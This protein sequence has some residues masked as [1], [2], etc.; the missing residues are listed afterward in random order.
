MSARWYRR[1]AAMTASHMKS[2]IPQLANN[3]SEILLAG[4]DKKEVES[5]LKKLG[6]EHMD[7]DESAGKANFSDSL[8][9]KYLKHYGT[10][11]KSS[12][13]NYNVLNN[14]FKNEPASRKLPLLFNYFLREAELEIRR[15]KN[16]TPEQ[17]N[18]LIETRSNELLDESMNSTEVME[19]FISNDL[20]TEDKTQNY[21]IHTNFVL[22]ILNN[23]LMDP[24]FKPSEDG[25]SMDQLVE[26]F[27]FSKIIPI[28]QKRQQG[29]MCSGKLIYSVGNVRM[30]PVNESFYINSLVAFGHYND[31]Y[32]LFKTRK[33]TLKEKWWYTIGLNILLAT[34][35][36]RGFKHLLNETDTM[37]PE[38]SPYLS[39]K[40]IKFSIKKFLKI[41]NVKSA[42]EMTNRFL[43]IVELKGLST[44]DPNDRDSKFRMF[45]DENDANEYLNQIEIPTQHDFITIINYYTY[46]KNMPM[47][48]LLFQKYL[49]LPDKDINYHD[50]IL[51]TNLNLLKDFDSFKKLIITG[52]SSNLTKNNIQTLE[53]EFQ[54]IIA[55]YD[56]NDTVIQSL[57]F[58]NIEDLLSNR[59]LSA[60]I[61]N[62]INEKL[63]I[64]PQSSLIDNDAQTQIPI[65]DSRQYHTLIQTLL[66]SGKYDKAEEI[67]SNLEQSFLDNNKDN[68]TPKVSAHI[69]AI[70]VDH[71]RNL[72]TAKQK[73]FPL[74]EID[75][76]V[77]DI[78]T[79]MNNLKIPYNSK[80]IASLLRYYRGRKNLKACYRIINAIFEIPVESVPE[81]VQNNF[82]A[83]LF[84]RRDINETLYTEIW[85]VYYNYYSNESVSNIPNGK[86]SVKR[87]LKNSYLKNINNEIDTMPEFDVE[88]LL[89]TMATRDNLLPTASLYQTIIAVFLKSNNW[90]TIPA[91]LSMMVNVHSVDIDINLFKYIVIGIRDNYVKLETKRLKSSD[92]DMALTVAHRRAI[93][94]FEK[95]CDD[96]IFI[97][98]NSFKSSD[99]FNDIKGENVLDTLLVQL[100]TLIKYQNPYDVHF[101]MVLEHFK[102]LEINNEHMA[103]IIALVN[104][105]NA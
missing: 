69:Y 44:N 18:N 54:N 55:N 15:L 12:N 94:M 19:E 31:A 96:K 20:A 7:S 21:L 103:N 45:Q 58:H 22:R 78:L 95:K 81:T 8:F 49:E 104:N 27:E 59:K 62:I 63:N 28:Q 102:T 38:S 4:K 105:N 29:I 65:R 88:W 30:D 70:Y 64:D 17:I 90:S 50:L 82:K 60:A 33:D 93:K 9:L 89:K 41:D 97:G 61:R 52:S 77:D 46:K 23:L 85:K 98:V 56:T 3:E 1:P 2:H 47:V 35:N 37:F 5:N 14:S 67:L 24:T 11:F 16:Y 80:L 40:V 73:R 36:L 26:V 87:I 74:T 76:L 43:Q 72:A 79:R 84:Q 83:T 92:H 25:V 66:H 101:G 99:N 48:S 6:F 32:K 53:K 75:K 100:L 68:S 42:N 51:R 57:L 13:R 34:N 39:M 91:I 86:I 71:Y 10:G